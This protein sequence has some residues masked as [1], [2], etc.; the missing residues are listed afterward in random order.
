MRE[1]GGGLKTFLTP[2]EL[3][4]L[5]LRYGAAWMHLADHGTALY[6]QNAQ[7][8]A[9]DLIVGVFSGQAAPHLIARRALGLERIPHDPIEEEEE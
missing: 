4:S 9:M 7:R 8:F 5:Q 1:A 3:F 6:M 2:T